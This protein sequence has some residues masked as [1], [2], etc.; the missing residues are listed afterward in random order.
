MKALR[1]SELRDLLQ[2]A[3]F[4][5]W[6]SELTRAA[7]SLLEAAGRH[8][9]LRAQAE[10]MAHKAELAQQAAI[11]AFSEGGVAEEAAAQATADAQE[12]ENR[13]LALVA[14][15]EEQ[16]FRTSDLWYRLGG[17]ERTVE[18]TPE[19]P[20]RRQLDRQR[21]A[22]AEEYAAEDQRRDR[23]WGEVEASWSRSFERSLM[24]QEHGE[25]ARRVRREAERLFRETEDRRSRA[26]Q[27]AAEAEAAG[28]EEGAAGQV[29]A[30]LLER[31]GRELGCQPGDRFLYWRHLDDQRA[32]FAVALTDDAEAFNVEVKALAIYTV[33]P[34]RGLTFLAPARDG[35]PRAVEEG[36][37]RFEDYLLG[38]R[39]GTRAGVGDTGDGGPA[40][41]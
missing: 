11:D 2:G 15:Y 28:R 26:R 4:T 41:P 18:E 39:Q 37:R 3:P 20:G 9:E 40:K 22:L 10:I 24:A 1:L 17:L 36:D 23:L 8:Q 35:L 27:L 14:H 16:R 31:A 21:Q 33:G 30:E 13:A 7:R 32:A 38:P 12:A 5:T 34:Q 6:W 19:G 29:R 25:Q